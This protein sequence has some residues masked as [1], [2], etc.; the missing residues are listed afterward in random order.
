M[1]DRVTAFAR[2]KALV[3]LAAFSV[4]VVAAISVGIFVPFPGLEQIRSAAAA[5]G[6][7]GAVVFAIG[8]GLVT[9][10]PVPKNVLGIA[11]G[12]VWGFGLGA[13]LVYVGAL[14]GAA[15]AF[16][17][18]RA[19]GREAVEN[20]TGARVER[21]DAI[22]RRRGLVSIIGVRLIP[23]LPFTA[24]NYT[25]GLTAVRTRDY[26]LGTILGIIP[27]TLAYVA[28]GGF[29]FQPGPGLYI[30]LGA[31]GAL[32]IAGAIVGI[33]MRRRGGPASGIPEGRASA[34]PASAATA[35]TTVAPREPNA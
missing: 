11:A 3:K 30:A 8:Y 27:G 23:V 33:R 19:L 7:T 9:L 24:I 12:A 18:G 13:L 21:I 5:A 31:L 1:N 17:I 35:P 2:R 29:G 32:T 14:L 10:T 15:L 6:W 16:G 26:A 28:V 20:F 34:G 25:A 22:L 4:F